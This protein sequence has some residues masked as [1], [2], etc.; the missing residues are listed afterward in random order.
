LSGLHFG[1]AIDFGTPEP[2]P[3]R[4][5]QVA[6]LL[7]RYAAAGVTHLQLRVAPAGLPSSVVEQTISLLGEHVLP[8][9]M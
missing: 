4:I 2:L 9:W 6:G 7:E 5:K 3:D 1:L 8:Y